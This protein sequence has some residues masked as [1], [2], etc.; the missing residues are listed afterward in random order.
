L[1]DYV[2]SEGTPLSR[3]NPAGKAS[4]KLVEAL[5]KVGIGGFQP[6]V[7]VKESGLHTLNCSESLR[8]P[9]VVSWPG[10]GVARL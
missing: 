10:T 9:L 4:D 6:V 2:S 3:G 5:G 1:R 8:N 7:V